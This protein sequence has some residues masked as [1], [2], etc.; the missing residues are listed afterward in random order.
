[1]RK[2]VLPIFVLLAV[3]A[4]SQKKYNL[5]I[6]TELNN[7][8]GLSLAYN[9]TIPKTNFGVGLGIEFNDISTKELGGIMPTL[10]ARYYAKLGKSTLIPLAQLGYNIYEHQYTKFGANNEYK[11]EGGAG[12]SMGLGY[13]Y[14]INAKG[15][16]P[17]TAFKYRSMQYKLNDPILPAKN[18]TNQLKI[19]LGWRF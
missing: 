13:S 5:F 16:G 17:F 4:S 7:T 8:K 15:S 10:D 3:N 18:N 9:H 2:I 14:S 12:F 11:I 6:A 19:S 1:M